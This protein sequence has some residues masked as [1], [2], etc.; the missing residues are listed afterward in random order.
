MSALIPLTFG[1]HAIVDDSDFGWLSNYSWFARWSNGCWYAVRSETINGKYTNFYMHREIIS[2]RPGFETHHKNNNGLDNQRYNLV[3]CTTLQNAWGKRKLRANKTIPFR[4]VTAKR[5]KFRARIVV[6]GSELNL[7]VFAT[8]EDA[9]N[10][11]DQAAL[12]HFG[13]FASVNFPS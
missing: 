13:E 1:L 7:G 8:P 5:N 6:M 9:A 10:A 3:E 4:G 12:T 2:A 11:Y